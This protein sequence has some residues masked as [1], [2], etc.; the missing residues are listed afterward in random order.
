M[1]VEERTSV[2]ALELQ[3]DDMTSASSD[4]TSES[5]TEID[6][7][8]TAETARQDTFASVPDDAGIESEPADNPQPGEDKQTLSLS[9]VAHTV[10]ALDEV[11]ARAGF[12][13]LVITGMITIV[14]GLLGFV[15]WALWAPLN[16][17]IMAPGLI[18]VASGRQTV[19]HLEGGI[20]S[21]I[22]VR[23]GAQ[24]SM[25]QVLLRLDDTRTRANLDMLQG[26][27]DAAS[28]RMARL[29]AERNSRKR[30]LFPEALTGRAQDSNVGELMLGEVRLFEAR[31][32]A[33]EG[34]I[35]I[36]KQRKVQYKY[37]REASMVQ[38]NSAQEQLVLIREELS[39]VK[40]IY[41][42]GIY[43]KPKYLALKRTAASLSGVIGAHS[44]TM[45][46]IMQ[47]IHEIELEIIAR[48]SEREH[49][50][51]T[52]LQA[53]NERMFDLEEQRR[54]AQD[55]LTRLDVLAPVAGTVVEL[56]FH[57][58]QG[59]ITPG[60][61]ILDIVPAD[62]LLIVEAQVRPADIDA[63]AI[64]QR[65]EILLTAYDM[66]TTPIVN[67]TVKH[68]SADRLID[69]RGFAYFKA[70]I[71]IDPAAREMLRGVELYP[72]MPA[73]VQIVTAARTAWQY[74]WR[75]IK[76][77]MYRAGREQ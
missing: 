24:V 4:S 44:A 68:I 6:A 9:P 38:R 25:G 18:K 58:P 65:A 63:I 71:E 72:G 1:N 8:S 26:R 7:Q 73:D 22:L 76:D 64:G 21:E 34:Y 54:A 10:D 12:E 20:I 52:E 37:A 60:A 32:N 51:A 2:S 56:Q 17:A 41:E 33:L 30:I 36:L 46:R 29:T 39:L 35:R 45:T 27:Y 42:L 77:A 67:G 3:Q 70:R 66:R 13:P 40:K 11:V 19:Q 61:R 15:L 5:A 47:Q 57:T 75:P 16:S 49:E 50:I 53:V 55:I 59:V 74:F 62:D 31:R 14:L 48:N 43:E 69:Q 28:M 23:E